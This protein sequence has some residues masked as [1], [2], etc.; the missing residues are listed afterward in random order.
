MFEVKRE[1]IEAS[2]TSIKNNYGDMDTYLEKEYGLTK[3][4]RK[5]LKN[6]LLY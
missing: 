6:R 2:F 3:K 4:K 1:L 5:E